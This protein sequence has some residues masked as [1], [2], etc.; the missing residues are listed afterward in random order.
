MGLSFAIPIDVANNVRAAARHDRP[1]DA[2]P[3]RRQHPAGECG[4]GRD[5]RPRPP[6][7]RGWSARS[8][9]AARRTRPGSSPRTSSSVSTASQIEQSSELPA[10]IAGIKPGQRGRPRGL[11]RP[12][13]AHTST[14]A[15]EELKDKAQRSRASQ[16]RRQEQRQA[17]RAGPDRARAERRTRRASC[18]PTAAWWSTTSTVRRPRRACGRAT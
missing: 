2:R 5:L 18:T 16:R 8:T 1:R 10:L 15:V 7:R 11:A 3:H 14:S 4:A 6:A 13:Q 9:T 17:R 12:R